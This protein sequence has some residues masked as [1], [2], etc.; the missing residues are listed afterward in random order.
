MNVDEGI[1]TF[2][3]QNFTPAFFDELDNNTDNFT[4]EARIACGSNI[5]CLFDALATQN[6]AI[7]Q[8]TREEQQLTDSIIAQVGTLN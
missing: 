8:S 1:D 3:C 7:G 5:F 4:L 6:I 2:S